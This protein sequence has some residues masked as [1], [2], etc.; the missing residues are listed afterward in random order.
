MKIR[1]HRQAAA[2]LFVLSGLLAGTALPELLRMGDGSYAGFTSLYS[3][4]KYENAVIQFSNIFPYILSLR[5]RT[6]L[7][8]WMS[9]FTVAGLLFHLAYFWWL[10]ASAG[11]LI[12][13]FSLRSG[14]NGVILFACSLLPQW[15]LYAAMW[16]RELSV[17]F[18]Q[19]GMHYYTPE[20][21]PALLMKGKQLNELAQMTGL[22]VLGCACE[23]L[24]GTQLLK[25]FFEI[26]L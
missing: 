24:L 2:V 18:W 5:L 20:G 7:F 4:Q 17:L 19:S 22:C 16:R 12:S 14:W 1:N 26:F 6:L 9:C 3:L 13:L 8:L 11:M 15:I 23:A 21:K 10:A 25:F